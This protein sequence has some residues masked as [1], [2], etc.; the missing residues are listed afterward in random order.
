MDIK[1]CK[2]CDSKFYI[3]IPSPDIWCP[4]CGYLLDS[5]D[6]GRR[7]TKRELFRKNCILHNGFGSLT[8]K[9]IDISQGGVGVN[10]FEESLPFSKDDKL[11]VDIVDIIDTEIKKMALVAWT[12]KH[13][14]NCIRVG[15]KFD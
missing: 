8:A 14:N 11:A 9:T 12:K 15:L 2:R 7:T 6:L 10:I 1:H 4:F 5:S 3:G 13:I